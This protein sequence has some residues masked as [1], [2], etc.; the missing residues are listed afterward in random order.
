M[1]LSSLLA[2]QVC[3]ISSIILRRQLKSSHQMLITICFSKWKSDILLDYSVKCGPQ[4][5]ETGRYPPALKV[6]LPSIN[7]TSLYC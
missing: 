2:E 3:F 7:Q 6:E 1:M 5:Q 4:S